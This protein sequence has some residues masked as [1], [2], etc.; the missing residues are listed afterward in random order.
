MIYVL[1]NFFNNEFIKSPFCSSY[2]LLYTINYLLSLIQMNSIKFFCQFQLVRNSEGP[3]LLAEFWRDSSSPKI[4]QKWS[5][6]MRWTIRMPTLWFRI[7]IYCLW[8]ELTMTITEDWMLVLRS[9][10][11][12][13]ELSTASQFFQY[14]P[15]FGCL[16][17]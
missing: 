12:D 3:E 1:F 8:R 4:L 10:F 11:L 2:M 17:I 6:C 16:R 14:T 15:F 5:F 7:K 9:L 13:K